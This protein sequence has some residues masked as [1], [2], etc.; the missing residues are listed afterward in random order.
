MKKLV[1]AVLVVL[2]MTGL[3]VA[4]EFEVTKKAGDYTVTIKIDRNPPVTG[5]N[6]V[7]VVIKDKG[8]ADVKDAKVSVEYS[9]PA[10]SGMPAM[11]YKADA[12]LTGSEYQAKLNYSMSG[13]W[14]TI[15]RISRGNKKTQAKFN[16]D[17]R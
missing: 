3:A 7:S 5:E 10:M 13:A 15:V 11:Q 14:D 8:G 12:K 16:I 9:M 4:K 2:M 1:L 17:V 6:K